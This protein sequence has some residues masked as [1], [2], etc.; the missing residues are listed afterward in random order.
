MLARRKSLHRSHALR[1]SPF[2]VLTEELLTEYASDGPVGNRWGRGVDRQS[3]SRVG[4]TQA[5][6]D[7]FHIHSTDDQRGGV[8]SPEVVE[9]C[10]CNPA[11]V[12][13]KAGEPSKYRSVPGIMGAEEVDRLEL[14]EDTRHVT[15]GGAPAPRAGPRTVRRTLLQ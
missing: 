14:G 4:V 9:T 8:Q 5:D 7:S 1:S 11:P 3:P 12:R 10:P 15:L 6:L 2:A 13:H